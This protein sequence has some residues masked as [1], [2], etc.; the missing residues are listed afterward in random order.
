VGDG[1][2][3][4][5]EGFQGS[6][7]QVLS[8]K[9]GYSRIPDSMSPAIRGP[10]SDLGSG[11]ALC[12]STRD[13]YGR[14]VSAPAP[15]PGPY[16]PPTQNDEEEAADLDGGMYSRPP[17]RSGLG[18]ERSSGGSDS[19]SRTSTSMSDR[20]DQYNP[21]CL[22]SPS[23][24]A[25]QSQPDLGE[26]NEEEVQEIQIC[27]P[28]DSFAT[29]SHSFTTTSQSPSLASPSLPAFPAEAQQVV[30]PS[31]VEQGQGFFDLEDEQQPVRNNNASPAQVG[32]P[33][34]DVDFPSVRIGGSGFPMTGFGGGGAR[35]VSDFGA[36]LAR[37]GD[38]EGP[39]TPC[40]RR[41]SGTRIFRSSPS[42][43]FFILCS[44]EIYD[45]PTPET[46]LY[47]SWY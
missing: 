3:E 30:S 4:N 23:Q 39:S 34:A 8:S 2:G 32:I 28:N 44:I 27:F 25:L 14:F 18:A 45:L 46:V 1:E 26:Q 33:K 13:D 15:A 31:T 38:D 40:D 9:S 16:I 6:G 35:K 41:R 43:G 10:G 17:P 47:T 12:G 19:R 42:P 20:L 22:T 5:F 7:A 36:F 21:L 11:S 29:R 37:R 24:T